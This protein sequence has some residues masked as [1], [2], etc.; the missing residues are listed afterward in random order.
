MKKVTW[1]FIGLSFILG[2]RIGSYFFSPS[3]EG[4][5]ADDI[6]LCNDS[7]LIYTCSMHP[8]VQQSKDGTCPVCAMPLTKGK[9]ESDYRS[10]L[11]RFTPQAMAL[12]NIQIEPV[13][14]VE[15]IEKSLWL[16]GNIKL[17]ETNVKNQI[18]HLPGRI[19]KL[20]VK[21]AGQYIRKGQP[22]A[23]I[24]SKELIAV[25]EAFKFNSKSPSIIRAAHNNLKSWKLDFKQIAH[26]INS[27]DYHQAVDVY[28]DFSGYVLDR[29]AREGDHARNSHMGTP[30]LLYQVV[31]LSTVWAEFEVAEQ[32]LGWI[33]ENQQV[34]FSTPAHPQRLFKAN[35]E[36]V[37][38]FVDPEKRV[39]KIRLE[40]PN[41]EKWLKPGMFV[42]GKLNIDKPLEK[43]Y[44]LIPKS[45]VLWTGESSVVY[46]KNEEFERIPVFEKQIVQ[47]GTELG[48]YYLIEH[49]IDQGDQIVVNGAFRI[50]AVAHL[51][52]KNNMLH[53]RSDNKNVSL[54]R[55]E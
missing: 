45:A 27:P 51:N 15:K 23:R 47:L 25:I 24:Y 30:T 53:E 20:F 38:F 22:I 26:L 16:R 19:E 14:R 9:S 13:K 28:A 43:A 37:D 11:I 1:L 34:E 8:G 40:V 5:S 6:V 3:N 7:E 29:S 46:I 48:D 50:D 31:D 12:A 44:P 21:E 10:D 2:L 55:R 41:S 32:D 36:Y 17:N 52:Q 39:G 49:G 54:S 35:I 4:N 18:A 33:Q 42:K